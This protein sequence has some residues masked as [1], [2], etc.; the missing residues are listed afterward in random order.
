ME[1]TWE[2]KNVPA[3]SRERKKTLCDDRRRR[4]ERRGKERQGRMEL[5]EAKKEKE[6][7]CYGKKK[8]SRGNFFIN[9]SLRVNSPFF[10]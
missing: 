10:F 6:P 1:K 7:L 2:K 9:V 3:P 5:R 4:K 8:K